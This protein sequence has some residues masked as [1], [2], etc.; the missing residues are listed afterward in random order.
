MRIEHI[1]VGAGIQRVAT[2]ALYRIDAI[3]RCRLPT[4]EIV[5]A[6]RCRILA[7]PDGTEYYL[8]FSDLCDNFA[9]V[10]PNPARL[11]TGRQKDGRLVPADRE[12]R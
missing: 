11:G 12:Q 3:G 5:D 9:L 4:G 8:T 10:H 2:T 1:Q 6:C 7:P